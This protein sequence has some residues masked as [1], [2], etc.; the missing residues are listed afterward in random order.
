[1]KPFHPLTFWGLF[2]SLAVGVVAF[3]NVPVALATVG[4][5]AIVVFVWRGDGPWRFSFQWALLAGLFLVAIRAL[6][7]MIIG[8]PRL[9]N[10]LF[11]LPQI[12]LPSWLP[13]IRLGGAVT[14]ERLS[15]SLHEG[16][17]I[18][19][20][21]AL[22]GAANSLTSPHRLLR[23]LPSHVFQIGVT[24]TIATSVFPQL[25]SSAI[26]IR[27]AQLLRSGE[28][29][30]L[31]RVAVPLFEESLERAVLLAESME[32]RGF[33]QSKRQSRYRPIHYSPRDVGIIAFGISCA[34]L[35]VTL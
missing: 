8:V 25:L 15:S 16:V 29:P 27:S 20:V 13:G 12:R 22:F 9:G 24:L 4:G 28:K 6:T 2:T 33:G 31:H 1:M 32:A 10:V 18:A 34:L 17:I 11:T 35:A 30:P 5:A 19:T 7:G 21:I 14:W 23:V 3:D 26:R